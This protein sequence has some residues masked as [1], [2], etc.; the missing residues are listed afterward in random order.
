LLHT[1]TLSL[2]IICLV[3]SI[4]NENCRNFGSM[5]FVPREWA[6]VKEEGRIRVAIYRKRNIF[7][8]KEI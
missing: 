7:R 5:T 1:T 3:K 4:M 8:P 6:A 2:I